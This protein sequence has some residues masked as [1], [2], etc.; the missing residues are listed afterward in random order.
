MPWLGCPGGGGHTLSL[1]EGRKHLFV[2]RDKL[3]L[4]SESDLGPFMIFEKCF[5]HHFCQIN[6]ENS[7]YG[8][9]YMGFT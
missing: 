8:S 2:A 3:L 5:Q 9:F 7:R 1:H 6:A 4:N